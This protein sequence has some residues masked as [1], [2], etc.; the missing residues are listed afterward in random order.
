MLYDRLYDY[1]KKGVVP[2]HMPGHKRNTALLGDALPYGVDITE[3]DGFD[4]LHDMRG[5]LK[6]TAELA[7]RLYRCA[8]AYPLV[9]GSTGGILAAVYGACRP[10][11]TVIMARNCH[12]SVYNAA[13]INRLKPAY[14]LPETDET[15]GISGSVTPEQVEKALEQN[16]EAKL[17]VVTSPTY[18]GVVSDI[19]GICLSAHRRG[20]PV[21]VDAAHGAHLGFSGFFPPDAIGCGADLAVVSLHKTL[22]ALTQSALA[23]YNSKIVD[24]SRFRAALSVYQTSSPSYVLLSSVDACVRL[25]FKDGINLFEYYVE[26]IRAF[27]ERVK[28]LH[29]LKAACHGADGLSE[30]PSFFGFDPGKLAIVTRGASLDGKALTGPALLERLRTRYAIELE[31]A[32]AGYAVAMTSVCDGADAFRRLSDALLDIDGRSGTSDGGAVP[33]HSSGLPVMAVTPGEADGLQGE[34]RPLAE[35]EGRMSLEYVWAY[36]PGIPL[37]VPGE[38]IGSGIIEQVRQLAGAGVAVKS[39]RGAVPQSVYCAAR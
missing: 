32:S 17:V 3:I 18:E 1:S 36:P 2:M 10:G 30:H 29:K 12:K 14:I 39:T 19:G 21:L 4:D 22:P 37:V 38:V 11:D 23:L 13:L 34:F 6:E 25:L 26:N 28:A 15:T 33:P 8:A 35:A 7:A 27:D 20:V 9:N 24:E 5:V 16:P 31:M